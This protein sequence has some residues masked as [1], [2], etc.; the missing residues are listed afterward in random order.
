MD[1]NSITSSLTRY[2]YVKFGIADSDDYDAVSRAYLYNF[3]THGS[4][5][6]SGETWKLDIGGQI[7]IIMFR[8]MMILQLSWRD[9]FQLGRCRCHKGDY[10]ILLPLV[11][12][13]RKQ[14]W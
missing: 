10:K 11:D 9:C 13:N 3:T 1:Q 7:V 8:V 2:K 4:A 14:G 12:D 6:S 5:P